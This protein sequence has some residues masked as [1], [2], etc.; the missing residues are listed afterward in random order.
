MT[1]QEGLPV[2]VLKLAVRSAEERLL[3]DA[4][5]REQGFF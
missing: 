1:M 5:I 4:L 2:N 3:Q